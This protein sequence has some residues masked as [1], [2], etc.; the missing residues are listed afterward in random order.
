M[1]RT[2]FSFALRRFPRF[3]A[4]WPHGGVRVP[5]IFLSIDPGVLAQSA[6]T[7][8][9]VSILEGIAVYTWQ[10]RAEPGARWQIGLQCTKCLWLLVLLVGVLGQGG[11]WSEI[12]NQVTWYIAM[13]SAY[14]WY[15]FIAELSRFDRTAPRWL[16][17]LIR[18]GV[19]VSWALYATNPWHHL[20][21]RGNHYGPLCLFFTYPFGYLVN[22]LSVVLNVR[23]A[24]GCH[25]LRRRQAWNFLVPYVLVWIGQFLS[26]MSW[27]DHFDPHALFYLL[28]GAA[29][30][31]AFFRWRAYSVLPLAQEAMVRSTIDALLVVDEDGFIARMNTAA[32]TSFSDVKEGDRFEPLMQSAS[33]LSPLPGKDALRAVEMAWK[34]E[35]AQRFFAVQTTPLTTDSGFRLGQVFCFKD[36]THEKRQQARIVEQEKA[37]SRLEER[38]SIARELHDGQGQSWSY[39]A[40]QLS[41][42]ERRIEQG[43]TAHAAVL[44]EEMSKIVKDS[45]LDLRESITALH[46]GSET[47]K[48][49]LLKAIEDQLNWYRAHCGWDARID[50]ERDCAWDEARLAPQC[51]VQ[52]LRIVQEALANARKHAQATR[53]RVG[54]SQSRDALCFA[55]EDNGAGFDQDRVAA[56]CGHHGLTMMR[57]RAGEIGAHFFVESRAEAGT[58]VTVRVP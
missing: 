14:I 6:F 31:W 41:A 57:E 24:L 7:L 56:Q 32:R 39:V 35:G 43:E 20:I 17:P 53:V 49:G 44:L 42:I 36:I 3:S 55:I 5:L 15:R 26:N 1:Y 52:L 28:A 46:I 18:A 38:A 54:I 4:A 29:T 27:A 22:L 21:A 16:E 10:F 25:G 50:V 33:A 48:H 9:V 37:I 51:K 45:H 34:Q 13:T 58:R 11:V 2:A 30:A 8:C 47:M 23:W 19:L 40:M 12:G